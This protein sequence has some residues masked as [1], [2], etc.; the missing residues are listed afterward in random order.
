MTTQVNLI[1]H[2]FPVIDTGIG[3]A[4]GYRDDVDMLRSI[5]AEQEATLSP[6]GLALLDQVNADLERRILIG[7]GDG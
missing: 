3:K 7:D 1:A 6:S 5:R 4:N 2:Q